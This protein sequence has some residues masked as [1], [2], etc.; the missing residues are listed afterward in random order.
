MRR[1]WTFLPAMLWVIAAHCD[2]AAAGGDALNHDQVEFTIQAETELPNDLAEV[3]LAAQA[4]HGDP[5]RV[6]K[7]INDTMTWALNQVHGIADIAANSG[8][9]Q[10]YPVY[11]KTRLDHWRGT[12]TLVLRSTR[13]EALNTLVGTLQ[14]RLQ[15][16][17]MRFSVSPDQ[18]QAGESRLI[19]Q[20]LDRFKAR[21]VRIQERLGAKGYDIVNLKVGASGTPPA[22]PVE[23]M[24]MARVENSAPVAGEAG[25]SRQSFSVHAVIRLRF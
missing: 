8:A 6:A 4:E 3:V 18:Q 13:I 22:F 12:Q 11:D 9:Y 5:A 14:R 20:A 2:A 25:T 1:P 7:E 24:A 23:R 16:Q 15:V 21:A 17:N 19:D 10:T